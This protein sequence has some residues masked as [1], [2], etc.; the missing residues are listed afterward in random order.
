MK[1]SLLLTI[2]IIFC[3]SLFIASSSAQQAQFLTTVK[4]ALADNPPK[5]GEA[6]QRI[7]LT[8]DDS[9]TVLVV[10]I[11]KGGEAK[12]HSHAANSETV[13][14]YKGTGQLTM[15]GKTFDLKAG[16]LHFNPK[17]ATHGVKNLGDGD[18]IA[19]SV[20]TPGLK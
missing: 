11:A 14:I 7:K 13:F 6:V 20:F 2:G 8:G 4:K 10:R 9:A 1:R 17:G 18:L 16:S 19:I 5:P 12:A 15:E 3:V